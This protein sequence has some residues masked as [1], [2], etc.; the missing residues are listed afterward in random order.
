VVV[1]V[2]VRGLTREVAVERSE[3]GEKQTMWGR[4]EGEEE[5]VASRGEPPAPS[6][7]FPTIAPPIPNWKSPAI[8]P[9]AS[10]RSSLPV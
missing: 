3:E 8:P 2:V 4:E 10:P 9:A 5:A 6:S 7:L 1:V